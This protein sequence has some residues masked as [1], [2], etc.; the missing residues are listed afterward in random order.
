MA[1]FH[2]CVKHQNAPRRTAVI[3]RAINS[4]PVADSQLCGAWLDR[5]HGPRERHCKNFALLQ[6]VDG[7]AKL[8]PDVFRERTDSSPR[9]RMEDRRLHSFNVSYLGHS[10][11][12][13][14]ALPCDGRPLRGWTKAP[15]FPVGTGTHRPRKTGHNMRWRK[16]G[17]KSGLYTNPS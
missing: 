6:I 16:A 5:R 4:S 15:V 11:K 8:L 1:L 12:E 14:K 9:C 2:E 7:L 17:L 10:V 3:E 13:V